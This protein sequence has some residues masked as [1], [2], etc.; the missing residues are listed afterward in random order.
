MIC[1]LEITFLLDLTLELASKI[2]H[3][4]LG[5]FGMYQQQ[6]YTESTFQC[7]INEMYAQIIASLPLPPVWWVGP[8]LIVP[9]QHPLPRLSMHLTSS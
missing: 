8:T 1:N 3:Y 5:S 6:T 7:Q 9:S 4:I 2:S